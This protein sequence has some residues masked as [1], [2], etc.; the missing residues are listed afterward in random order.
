MSDYMQTC[1]KTVF[2]C[3]LDPFYAHL[4]SDT[5]EQQRCSKRLCMNVLFSR[6]TSLPCF[7]ATTEREKKTK[8]C[9]NKHCQNSLVVSYERIIVSFYFLHVCL[10][11][12]LL[13]FY[14]RRLCSCRTW[15][16]T[17]SPAC[18]VIFNWVFTWENKLKKWL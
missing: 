12:Y 16:H 2:S 8:K 10:S 9:D 5:I 15:I 18:I 13:D 11:L 6:S 4:Q 17:F 1:E 7:V 14:Q 3:F